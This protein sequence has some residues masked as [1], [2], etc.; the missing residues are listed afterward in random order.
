MLSIS[1]LVNGKVPLSGEWLVSPELLEDYAREM[2]ERGFG[3]QP[4]EENPFVFD[5]LSVPQKLTCI[6]DHI[7]DDAKNY[8][9]QNK[10][11]RVQLAGIEEINTYVDEFLTIE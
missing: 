6:D 2:W 5:D 8:A 11:D 3:P 9:R 10:V 4:T 1:Q 7:I